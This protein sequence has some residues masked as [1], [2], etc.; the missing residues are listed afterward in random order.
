[1]PVCT[2]CKV[3]KVEL[4][5]PH[6]KGKRHSWCRKCNNLAKKEARVEY[7]KVVPRKRRST[8]EC[9]LDNGDIICSKCKR[10]KAKDQYQNERPGQCRECRTKDAAVSRRKSGMQ[11]KKYS[12]I[13]DNKKLCMHCKTMIDL[14]EFSKTSRGLGGLSAYCKCCANVR[15]YDKEKGRIATAK[16]RVVNRE[17]HLAS[18]RIRMFERRNRVK[19]TS[20]GSLNAGVLRQLYAKETC[21][22]CGEYVSVENRTLDHIVPLI[23]GGSHSIDNVDMACWTCNCSKGSLSLN[24]FLDKRNK[25]NES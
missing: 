1:M 2:K 16:Y 4:D 12:V 18:H 3:D 22:Y 17:T 9:I 23:S 21:C 15:Y 8:E 14:S 6:T 11:E 19:V 13:E 25:S 20:D 5:F 7:R 10:P 24:E